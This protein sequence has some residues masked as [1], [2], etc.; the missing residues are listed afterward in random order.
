MWLFCN[1]LIAKGINLSIRQPLL[2]AGFIFYYGNF[3]EW[4]RSFLENPQKSE[5][6]VKMSNDYPYPDF[7][8]RMKRYFEE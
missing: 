6:S 1:L 5:L 2:K 7:T 4:I 3:S 8:K